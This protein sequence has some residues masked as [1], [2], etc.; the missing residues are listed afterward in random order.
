MDFKAGFVENYGLMPQ[1]FDKKTGSM[2]K[3]YYG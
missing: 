3:F 1:I 2:T